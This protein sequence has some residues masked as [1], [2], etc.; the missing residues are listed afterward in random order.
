MTV[1]V[2]TVRRLFRQVEVRCMRSRN[3]CSICLPD[4]KDVVAQF[5]DR[6][7]DNNRPGPDVRR[8]QSNELLEMICRFCRESDHEILRS[9]NELDEIWPVDV[10]VAVQVVAAEGESA[11]VVQDFPTKSSIV[12]DA[13]ATEVNR[14]RSLM[15]SVTMSRRWCW[16]NQ[17]VAC[18]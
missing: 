16:I 1:A 11:K 12:D 8:N 7:S 13:D 15:I 6:R 10:L 3:D 18:W 14:T 9:C 2:R 4:R 5:G 17:S